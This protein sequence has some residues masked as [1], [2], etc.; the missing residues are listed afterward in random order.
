MI[1]ALLD[2]WLFDLIIEDRNYESWIL[3]DFLREEY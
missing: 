3:T 2:E 1:K